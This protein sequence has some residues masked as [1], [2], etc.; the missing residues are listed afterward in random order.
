MNC[1]W[2]TFAAIALV[3]FGTF[4]CSDNL[5]EPPER[6]TYQGAE[7][8]QL[9]CVPNLDGQIT[10]DEL[11]AAL[12]VP[13]RY[14]I[15]PAGTT[16]PVDVAG[17]T[18]EA[19]IRVWD[20]STDNQDDLELELQANSPADRWF[21]PEFPGAT[22]VSALDAAGTL[23]GV[24]SEDSAGVY[25]HGYASP[26][27]E[28]ANQ[29]TLV[30]YDQPVAVYRFPLEVGASWVDVAEVRNATVAGLPYAGRDTYEISIDEIGEVWLP[31]VQFTDALRVR[32][33][34]T[35]SPAV[36]E[37][38]SRKQVAFVFECFG[39][40]A[41]ATSQNNETNDNFEIAVEQRR[42]GF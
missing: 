40:V 1:D 37:A 36:G 33:D 13:V 32:T 38:V 9:D 17:A 35:V 21:A 23:I 10:A 18:D 39:E 8:P 19:G 28:P 20:W 25:L 22:F 31:D 11:Q 4:A 15:N 29:K 27:E 12:D 30:V 6:G 3:G 42:L 26:N 34:I 2:K 5:T 16:R 41:R 14:R 7:P 24:Y